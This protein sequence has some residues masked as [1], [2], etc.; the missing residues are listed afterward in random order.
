MLAAYS[1]A[2]SAL[3]LSC[4][5][6][7]SRKT[8]LS[9]TSRSCGTSSWRTNAR[10]VAMISCCS[11]LSAKSIDVSSGGRAAHT[12]HDAGRGGGGAGPGAQQFELQTQLLGLPGGRPVAA[13]G[14]GAGGNAVDE[15]HDRAQHLLAHRQRPVAPFV[16]AARQAT[17]EKAQI[18]AMQ[19]AIDALQSPVGGHLSP[20]GDPEG[21]L[22]EARIVHRQRLAEQHQQIGILGIRG[23]ALLD[24]P[25]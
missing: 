17:L 25:Q 18:L 9:S 20:E 1:P 15:G 21:A 6:S 2:A 5:R 16:P 22:G 19:P 8:P 3:A 13:A 7:S 12:A 11:S 23:Q 24:A 10:V 4:A 14:Y